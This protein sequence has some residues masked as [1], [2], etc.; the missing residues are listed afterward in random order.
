MAWNVNHSH[1]RHCRKRVAILNEVIDDD[2]S[3][4][5][6]R[7]ERAGNIGQEP[8]SVRADHRARAVDN[9]GVVTVRRHAGRACFDDLVEPTYVIGMAVSDRHEPKVIHQPSNRIQSRGDSAQATP[10]AGVDHH[11]AVFGFNHGYAGANCL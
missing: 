2:G 9:T 3:A 6:R 1:L 4:I 7:N 5:E 8:T 11:H 10:G